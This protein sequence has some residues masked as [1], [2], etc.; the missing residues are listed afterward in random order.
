MS[1]VLIKPSGELVELSR[2]SPLTDLEEVTE[3][4]IS[5]GC[6]SGACGACAIEVLEGISN[7][8]KADD[9]E[10]SFLTALGYPEERY[11]LACQCRFQGNITIRPIDS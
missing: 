4:V 1:H 11:R 6:R 9:M 7:L 2:N 3:T 8:T 10:R 5:F